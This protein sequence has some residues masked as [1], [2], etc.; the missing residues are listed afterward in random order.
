M[1]KFDNT[2]I[3][4]C[5]KLYIMIGIPCSGKSTYAKMF[6][7][8]LNTIVISSDQIRKDLTGTY[9]YSAGD[10]DFVFASADFKIEQALSKGYNVAFDATNT[11][12][13]YR[14]KVIDIGQHF[15]CYIVAVVFRTPI[16]ICLDRNFKRD[17]ERKVPDE[18]I[19]RMSS[20]NLNIDK[21]EGFDEIVFVD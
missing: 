5:N 18:I 14:R 7:S 15:N 1:N 10:N 21:S 12:S 13:K 8:G 20:F 3:E 2:V 11:K 17:F 16:N 9:K 19:L 6:L 4:K